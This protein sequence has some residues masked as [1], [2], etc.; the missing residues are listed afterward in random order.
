MRNLKKNTELIDIEN[1]LEWV[2]K[3]G[4]GGQ[5]VQISCYKI[6]KC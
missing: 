1:I 6:N 5:K 3:M 4:E 2:D